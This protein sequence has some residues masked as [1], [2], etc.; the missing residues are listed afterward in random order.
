MDLTLPRWP[1]PS[2]AWVND[3]RQY[4]KLEV[5]HA[6]QMDAKILR[7]KARYARQLDKEN[8]NKH[9]YARVRGLGN[10]P[11]LKLARLCSLMP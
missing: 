4:V 9:A 8:H 6:L 1:L 7:D 5:E 3:V 2:S 10:P 11:S